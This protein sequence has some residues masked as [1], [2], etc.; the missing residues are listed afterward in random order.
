MLNDASEAIR[1]VASYRIA[2]L[3]LGQLEPELRRLASAG[4]GA[5]AELGD[6]AMDLFEQRLAEVTNAG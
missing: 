1:G 5:L 3:G 2:E 6:R 4:D